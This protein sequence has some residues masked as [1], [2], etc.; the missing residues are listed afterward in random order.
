MGKL[1]FSLDHSVDLNVWGCDES[2]AGVK[3]S[4]K[5]RRHEGDESNFLGF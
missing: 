1:T 5:A 3:E 2:V 4:G